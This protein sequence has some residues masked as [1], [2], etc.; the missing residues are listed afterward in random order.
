VRDVLGESAETPIFVE[1]LA[2]RGYRFIAP[3]QAAPD[4]QRASKPT[5]K[6]APKPVAGVIHGVAFDQ[7]SHSVPKEID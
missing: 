6:E 4:R 7:K 2:R 1:T 3:V 5:R